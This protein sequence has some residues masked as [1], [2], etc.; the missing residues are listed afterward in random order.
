MAETTE[1]RARRIL[2]CAG[3]GYQ[4]F[5]LPALILSLLKHF[6][7]DV[8][9]V[10]SPLAAKMT[11]V[12]S[13]EVASR[14]PVF[15]EMDDCSTDVYVPH[16]ELGRDVDLVLVYPATASIMGKIANGIAD[17][18]IAAIVL[19]T[20]APVFF[21]PIAN[22]SMLEHPA[23]VRNVEQLQND[24]YVVLPSP[25]AL[26]IATREG[27]TEG[28]GAFP[29]PTL[30]TRMASALRDPAA[31]RARRRPQKNA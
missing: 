30:L 22:P 17:E 1:R 18:L 21:V 16:I 19:A 29:L 20:E 5:N 12:Y 8:Q 25:P 6:A 2:L 13:V 24:G 9:V 14:H 15:V 10:L 3:G 27:L 11:S 28:G 31:S 7:D 26:E 4:V 23:V